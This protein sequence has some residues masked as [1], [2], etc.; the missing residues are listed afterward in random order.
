MIINI[1]LPIYNQH[2]YLVVNKTSLENTKEINNEHQDNEDKLEDIKDARGFCWNTT[3]KL[4]HGGYKGR[5]YI[6][7]EEIEIVNKTTTLEH[8]LIHLT[9]DILDYVGINISN[10]NHESF[11]YLYEHFL[12]ECKKEIS[13]L[14]I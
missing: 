2:V 1:E 6:T 12:I 10:S 13:K 8:E 3:F 7:L 4:P 11:T 5:F 9:W 14:A